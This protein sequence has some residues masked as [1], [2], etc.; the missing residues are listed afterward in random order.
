MIQQILI[1]LLSL[2]TKAPYSLISDEGLA[3]VLITS[4][5]LCLVKQVILPRDSEGLEALSTRSETLL[6]LMMARTLKT[7]KLAR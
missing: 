2:P 5:Y 6:E 4:E 3:R 1:N 7:R